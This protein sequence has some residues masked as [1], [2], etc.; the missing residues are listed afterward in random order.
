MNNAHE[1]YEKQ[2]PNVNYRV[3]K[4]IQCSYDNVLNGKRIFYIYQCNNN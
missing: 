3:T 2:T 4:P 1:M